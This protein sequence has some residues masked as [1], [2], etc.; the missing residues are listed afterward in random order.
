MSPNAWCWLYD[1]VFELTYFR[2]DLKNFTIASKSSLVFFYAHIC[3]MRLSR[4]STRNILNC[5]VVCIFLSF[6]N[7]NFM[8]WLFRASC[9]FLDARTLTLISP[10]RYRAPKKFWSSRKICANV[11]YGSTYWDSDTIWV[12]GTPSSLS[13]VD[14]QY[15]STL[16]FFQCFNF[17]GLVVS[18]PAH[19]SVRC[20]TRQTN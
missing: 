15:L 9:S 10:I 12:C 4:V 3:C 16:Y 1:V 6:T 5:V 20:W 14:R 8:S 7:F 2:S 13:N 11:E 18:F 17:T 19:Y